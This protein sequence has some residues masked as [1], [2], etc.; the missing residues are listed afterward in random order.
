[1]VG[2]G[3]HAK[4]GTLQTGGLDKDAMKAVFEVRKNICFDSFRADCTFAVRECHANMCV[5][6]FELRR[7]GRVQ[8]G[9]NIEVYAMDI[10][11]VSGLVMDHNREGDEGIPIQKEWT[12]DRDNDLFSKLNFKESLSLSRQLT[13][14]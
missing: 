13:S 10:P 9:K 2:E 4:F 12:G 11:R 7:I 8:E 14:I 1:M 6:P 5:E 3:E